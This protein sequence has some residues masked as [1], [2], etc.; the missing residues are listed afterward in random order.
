MVAVKKL[1]P[2]LDIRIIFYS[3]RAKDIRWAEKYGFPWAIEKI[4]ADW[5]K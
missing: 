3:K 4:P 2:T 5:L 1:H